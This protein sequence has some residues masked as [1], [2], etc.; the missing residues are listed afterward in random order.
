MIL[1]AVYVTIAPGRTDD[2]WAWAHDIVALWDQHN[3]KRH[4]GPYKG[5]GADG[6]D[7]AVWLT[8]HTS[9]QAAH[10]E[11]RAMYTTPDGRELLDKRPPLVA[12]TQVVNYTAFDEET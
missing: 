6:E 1:R 7:T 8:I 12:D 4:G 5:S 2:Y 10:D 3:I 11:F 9:E